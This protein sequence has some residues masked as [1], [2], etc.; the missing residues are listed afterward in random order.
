VY[1]T[2]TRY[3]PP[4]V[5][6]VDEEPARRRGSA[7]NVLDGGG[8]EDARDAVTD[9]IN[10]TR[11]APVNRE[12]RRRKNSDKYVTDPS[13]LNLQF[14]RWRTRPENGSGSGGSPAGKTV[15]ALLERQQQQLAASQMQQ[16]SSPG[17]DSAH[18][19]LVYTRLFYNAKN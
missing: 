8:P 5:V 18:T 3:D 9:E 13:E 7:D 19:R 11:S 2:E 12:L 10:G 15:G 4:N 17:A 1:V 16:Y 14:Q 6:V